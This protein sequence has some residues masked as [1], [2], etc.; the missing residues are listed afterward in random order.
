ME[1]PASTDQKEER[2]RELSVEDQANTKG[3][4]LHEHNN[5]LYTAMKYRF[6]QK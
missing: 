6:L 1:Y 3:L 4:N 5:L 2:E